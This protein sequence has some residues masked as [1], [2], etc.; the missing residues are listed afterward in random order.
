MKNREFGVSFAVEASPW[1][2]TSPG[3]EWQMRIF[4]GTPR[5]GSPPVCSFF[6][7][8][9]LV[10]AVPL[11][12]LVLVR[13][14]QEGPALLDDRDVPLRFPV[15]LVLSCTG[16]IHKSDVNIKQSEKTCAVIKRPDISMANEKAFL[17]SVKK[18]TWTSV[19]GGQFKSLVS[20][21]DAGL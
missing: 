15:F 12:S 11:P 5:A 9:V 18:F 17:K 1:P 13:V 7:L 14:I 16:Q 21:S 6:V 4:P 2:V 20:E 19:D 8:L 3:W 10:G